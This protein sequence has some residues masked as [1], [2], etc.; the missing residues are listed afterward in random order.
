MAGDAT[1]EETPVPVTNASIGRGNSGVDGQRYDSHGSQTST[2]D[3]RE[4]SVKAV[5]IAT[6]IQTISL[7]RFQP[8]IADRATDHIGL[9]RYSLNLAL[10]E[11][12]YPSIHCFEIGLRNA[13]HK[14]ISQL[15]GDDCWFE[16]LETLNGQQLKLVADANNKLYNSK[17]KISLASGKIIAELPLGFWTAFFN[18]RNAGNSLNVQLVKSVFSDAPRSSRNFKTIDVRLTRFREL[19]NRIFHHERIIHWNDLSDLHKQLVETISW[20]CPQL[21]ALAIK[22]DRFPIVQAKGLGPWLNPHDPKEL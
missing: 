4:L 8:F 22:H 2:K 14:Q 21:H 18:K 1:K 3:D 19:R 7:E 16:T 11:A 17:T 5:D 15:R 20:I 9:A 13:I 12:L 6:F 10:S